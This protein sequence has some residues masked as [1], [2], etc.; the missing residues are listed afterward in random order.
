MNWEALSAIGQLL[1]AAAVLITLI[2]LAIQIRQSTAAMNTTTYETIVTGFNDINSIV[3]DNPDV[4]SIL[5]RGMENPST[6][7]DVEAVRFSFL[8]RCW[9]NQ[10]LKLLRLYQRGALSAA[11]WRPFAEE[12][13]QAFSTPGGKLFQSENRLF[14][15][16]YVELAKYGGREVSQVRLG[17]TKGGVV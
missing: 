14:A 1:G 13:A 10:W 9:S 5:H 2:Y 11:E 17:E 3:V 6:L 8:F 4:A 16:L 12:A 15:E 7:S